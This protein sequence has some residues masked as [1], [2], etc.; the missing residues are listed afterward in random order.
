MRGETAFCSAAKTFPLNAL[1]DGSLMHLTVAGTADAVRQ[2]MQDLAASPLFAQLDEG[3][4][5][6]AEIVLA[7]VMNNIVE[8]AFATQSGEIDLV[9]EH[10]HGRLQCLVSDT[11]SAMPDLTLPKGSFQPLGPIED[12]P[13]GGF[14]WFLIRSLTEGLEYQRI[15]GVNQLSFALIQEQSPNCA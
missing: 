12:L 9:L 8:H 4:R 14:G 7:E 6:N 2:A 3:S 11:G 13:E 15:G 1:L 5:C 10:R